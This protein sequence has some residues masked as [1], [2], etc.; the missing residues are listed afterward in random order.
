MILTS[1]FLSDSGLKIVYFTTSHF[2]T[3]FLFVS[4]LGSHIII[5]I[6]FSRLSLQDSIFLFDSVYSTVYLSCSSITVI[7]CWSHMVSLSAFVPRYI[8][9]KYSLFNAKKVWSLKVETVF[10]CIF[11]FLI[12]FFH[13]Y[14]KTVLCVCLC[15]GFEY[16]CWWLF[17]NSLFIFCKI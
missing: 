16:F 4:P 5:S 10:V 15:F 9:F 2:N 1:N 7:H 13:I 6:F 3:L 11:F 12:R 8:L 17:F 14:K